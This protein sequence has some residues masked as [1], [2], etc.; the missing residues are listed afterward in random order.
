M[1]HVASVK[2]VDNSGYEIH[3]LRTADLSRDEL[4]KV[5]NE[6]KELYLWFSPT[7]SGADMRDRLLRH[8]NTHIS[9]LRNAENGACRGF[10]VYYT[11]T[12]DGLRVIFRDGTIV[13]DRSR[14]LYKALLQHSI[15]P[16]CHDYV[17]AMTQ[18]PRV[19]ETLRSFSRSEKIFP[20][21]IIVVSDEVREIAEKFC[22]AP[23]IALDTL[24]VREVYGEIRKDFEFTNSKDPKVKDFFLKNLG[25]DDGFFVVVPL[26]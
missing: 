1:I 3:T 13:R 11:E 7:S 24:I 21:P 5:V 10:S 25:I 14:G 16:E 9:I 20:S 18:N 8:R 6:I 17:V 19:Y 23:N 22:K 2:K 12:F 4:C 15:S 26:K